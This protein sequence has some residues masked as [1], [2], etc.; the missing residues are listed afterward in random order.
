MQPS[1]RNDNPAT[2]LVS[3]IMVTYNSAALL[4][5]CLEALAATHYPGYELIIVDNASSDGTTVLVTKHAPQAQ[6]LANRENLGFGRACNQGA[7]AAHGAL[8]VF[9]NPDVIVTPNW[10]GLLVEHLADRPEA[11]IIC[12]T[13]LYPDETPPPVDTPVGE[14]AAVPGC[15]LMIR[16][17]AWQQLGGFDERYFLYWE[18]TDLCWRAW[19]AGWRVLEDFTALVYHERGGSAG[20][21]RWDAE[22]T[23]NSLRTYLK[24]MR[25]RRVLPFSAV[26]ALKTAAKIIRFRQPAL[27]GA[28]AWNARHLGET[29]AMRREIQR[30]RRTTPT[31]LEQR[32]AAHTARN[33]RARRNRH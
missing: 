5:A 10:L 9:L 14:T 1:Q 29:L 22:A 28:W 3:L 16:C 20:G 19:L 12:P 4:P 18:D 26:L 7:R 6:L 23:K 24:T 32:I 11:G 13:T 21:R 2:P 33:Q 31:A 8:L 25:W 30:T 17:K 15:A 27:L